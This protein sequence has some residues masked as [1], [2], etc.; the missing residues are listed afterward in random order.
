[1]S[2]HVVVVRD[3]DTGFMAVGHRAHMRMQRALLSWPRGAEPD[4]GL[5]ELSGQSAGR[6]GPSTAV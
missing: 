1:M 4:L 5:Q 6:W 2:F 3:V